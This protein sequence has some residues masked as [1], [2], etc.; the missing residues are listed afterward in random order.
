MLVNLAVDVISCNSVCYMKNV[1]QVSGIASLFLWLAKWDLVPSSQALGE[2]LSRG[3]LV[4]EA[5]DSLCLH[6]PSHF[7]VQ[8]LILHVLIRCWCASDTANTHQSRAVRC[9]RSSECRWQCSSRCVW[10][11]L[12][13]L[14]SL[15]TLLDKPWALTVLSDV[16]SKGGDW[17]VPSSSEMDLGLS[18]TRALLFP[19][20]KAW[21]TRAPR[22]GGRQRIAGGC[23]SERFHPLKP[24][25]CSQ[26]AFLGHMRFFTDGNIWPVL[27]LWLNKICK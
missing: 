9:L 4:T 25:Y 8:M 14:L 13:L 10:E 3:V 18:L 7:Y 27:A 11:G 23:C 16:M 1:H 21:R 5:A 24:L 17:E 19:A 12:S 26:G 6:Q 2:L 20:G 15:Q 22:P